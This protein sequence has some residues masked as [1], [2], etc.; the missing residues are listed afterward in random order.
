MIEKQTDAAQVEPI[1]R[2]H[3]HAA[4]L[5]R[6]LEELEEDMV[7]KSNKHREQRP[8]V[9]RSYEDNSLGVWHVRCL[10]QEMLK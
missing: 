9:A 7:K 4:T 10:I 3:L 2:T 5:L 1:V 6:K 8:W